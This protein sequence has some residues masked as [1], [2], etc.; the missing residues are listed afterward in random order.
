[1]PSQTHCQHCNARLNEVPTVERIGSDAVQAVPPIALAIAA[2]QC[3][4]C[5]KEL[6]AG[7]VLC[8]E[9]GYDRRTRRK[10]ETIHAQSEEE[11]DAPRRKRL[12]A[13]LSKV[14]LG[15]G[16]HYARLVLL[17]LAVLVLL[18]LVCFGGTV[19]A[20]AAVPVLVLGG[21]AA[22][23]IVLL[24]AVL[25]VVGSVLCLWVG[26]PSRA[27][28]FIFGSLL[29]DALTLPL[30]VFVQPPELYVLLGWVVQLASWILFMQFLRRLAVYVDRSGDANDVMVF[31]TRGVALF[32]AVPLLLVLL[33]LYAS[34]SDAATAQG[35]LVAGWVIVLVQIIFM[36]QLAVGILGNIQSL[37][38]AITSQLP[39][40]GWERDERSPG[41]SGRGARQKQER[42]TS[43]AT[44]RRRRRGPEK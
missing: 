34:L 1:M 13:G 21:L 32:V 7:A 14:Q 17:L 40:R 31:I 33:G 35:L 20:W 23:G 9:C 5:G 24:A 38:A 22:L 8:I 37:R 29:L 30:A 6:P 25:G 19:R 39:R 28:W 42:M 4:G 16:F 2:G 36:V 26:R 10:R 44:T 3:P 18:G 43:T 11:P 27:W 41:H 15:L 12:P